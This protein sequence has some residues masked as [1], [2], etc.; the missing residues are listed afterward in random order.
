MAQTLVRMLCRLMRSK[1]TASTSTPAGENFCIS[2]ENGGDSRWALCPFASGGHGQ[3]LNERTGIEVGDSIP[4]LA[5]FTVSLCLL[6]LP[7]PASRDLDGIFEIQKMP[8]LQNSAL[9]PSG[10]LDQPRAT[11]LAK[12]GSQ[13]TAW[14]A[15]RHGNWA[16]APGLAEGPYRATQSQDGSARRK[17]ASRGQ[18]GTE[19]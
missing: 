12:L 16:P 8:C 4:V 17:V 18:A 1:L 9:R 6:S 7:S 14:R 10:R 13:A 11:W 5:R 15:G 19:N 3:N 2:T